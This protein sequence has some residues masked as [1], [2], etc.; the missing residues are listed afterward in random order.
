M[1]SWLLHCKNCHKTFAYSLMPDTSCLPSRPVF[2]AQGRE[3]ECPSCKT[4]F[5]YQQTDLGFLSNEGEEA[6]S[7]MRRSTLAVS[8]GRSPKKMKSSALRFAQRN[9]ESRAYF[10]ARER[11]SDQRNGAPNRS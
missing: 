9:T 7:L 6:G 4:K 5:T 8:A 10:Q 3:R 11:L 1:A 2:P